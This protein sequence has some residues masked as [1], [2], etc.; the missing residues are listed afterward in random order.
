VQQSNVALLLPRSKHLV[1]WGFSDFETDTN[2]AE[3]S[4]LSPGTRVNPDK[5]LIYWEIP[6][7]QRDRVYRIDW[8]WKDR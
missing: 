1:R 8:S 7:P 2:R 6:Q 3:P 5:G 4:D